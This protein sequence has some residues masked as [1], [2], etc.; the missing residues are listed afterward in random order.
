MVDYS[1]LDNE[2]NYL[3]K[4]FAA[5]LSRIITISEYYENLSNNCKKFIESCIKD[6]ENC[7]KLQFDIKDDYMSM[8]ISKFFDQ[9]KTIFKDY[10]SMFTQ[11]KNDFVKPLNNYHQSITE[12]YD[13][14]LHK[15]LEGKKNIKIL[16]KKL[17][18]SRKSHYYE[19]EKFEKI[20]KINEDDYT[21][22]DVINQNF[23]VEE[24]FNIYKKQLNDFNNYINQ[25]NTEYENL[26]NKIFELEE[27]INSILKKQFTI[28]HNIEEEYLKNKEEFVFKLYS[29]KKDLEKFKKELIFKGN[30]NRIKF[31]DYMSYQ[32][33][34][35]MNSKEKSNEK[36]KGNG[37]KN[38]NDYVF[39]MAI[40]EDYIYETND[41]DDDKDFNIE[42]P[43][44][45]NEEI[46]DIF[47]NN[48][49]KHELI[50]D[51][52][53]QEIKTIL[54]EDFSFVKIFIQ[55]YFNFLNLSYFQFENE[56]NFIQ[57]GN[58][59]NIILNYFNSSMIEQNIQTIISILIIGERNYYNNTFL[60]S[61]IWEN[62]FFQLKD[63]WENLIEN[64]FI[65]KISFKIKKILQNKND[66]NDNTKK[67][68]SGMFSSLMKYIGEDLSKSTSFES[69]V[70][71][72][73]KYNNQKI[74]KNL[75][76]DKKIKDYNLLNDN[77]K[78][79]IDSEAQEIIKKIIFEFIEHLLNYNLSIPDSI[80]LIVDIGSKFDL[81]MNYINY[82]S[83]CINSA[84]LSICRKV[85]NFKIKKK[86]ELIRKNDNITIKLKYPCQMKKDIEKKLIL[87]NLFN[88][89]KKDELIPFFLLNKSLSE[90]IKYSF[91]L[92]YLNTNPN[93]SNKIRLQ[94]WR[95][96]LKI[97]SI[98]ES[99]KNKISEINLNEKKLKLIKQDVKRTHIGQFSNE[100]NQSIINILMKVTDLLEKKSQNS[101]SNEKITNEYYQGMNYLSAFFYNI[102]KNEDESIYFLYSILT[103][104]E[105]KYIY[106][107]EMVRLKKFFLTFEK[108]LKLYLPQIS[109]YFK[110]NSIKIN[111]FMTPFIIT[112][113]TNLI[114]NKENIPIILLNIWDEFLIKG[115]KSLMTSLLT[116][117]SFHSND[118]LSKSGED[119][120]KFLINNLSSSNQFSDNNFNLWLLEKKKFKIKKKYLR[121][122]E[123]EVQFENN[124]EL[125][126]EKKN[127]NEFYLI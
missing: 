8:C 77:E 93:I 23:F 122:L 73:S 3:K 61:L 125:E 126:N 71:D 67:N 116:L 31:E 91:Y 18:D 42:P 52:N 123:D 127:L 37:K 97:K 74:L 46:I 118:I 32:D 84:S 115:W 13:E 14:I 29:S 9:Q 24:T 1:N 120:L 79:V 65:Q 92:N 72:I 82:Y 55:K 106:D 36:N 54:N 26:M 109:Y 107:R 56:N 83:L 66:N 110:K 113:F 48:I 87:L 100:I 103:N 124:I 76:Y 51:N 39:S 119:L 45:S 19:C 70:N 88:Y 105:L 17:I 30:E 59:F 38:K 69:S 4:H 57:I 75:G 6:K 50:N 68:K 53:I 58:L 11:I 5:N 95:I 10:N 47:M 25:Y 60:C 99:I 112:I 20:K 44:K 114:Q 80:N 2:Y 89:L 35:L 27:D 90:K 28:L 15:L 121:I 49:F 16:Y 117:I 104:T 94:I 86:I 12:K 33:F 43:K 22:K 63:N 62:N 34:L 96:I 101:D 78:L 81:S 40:S 21:H 7:S 102:T 64:K 111:Y 85:K 98:S 41:D 108:L